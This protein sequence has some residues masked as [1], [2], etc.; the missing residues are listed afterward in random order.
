MKHHLDTLQ[1]TMK[2]II[3]TLFETSTDLMILDSSS[4]GQEQP[5]KKRNRVKKTNDQNN[6]VILDFKSSCEIV[7]NPST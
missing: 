1:F 7:Q 6:H 3:Q 4:E 2:T 5:K